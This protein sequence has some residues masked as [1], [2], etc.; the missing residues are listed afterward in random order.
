MSA[1]RTES[2]GESVFTAPVIV[3]LALM[4]LL[5]LSVGAAFAPLGPFKTSASLGVAGIKVVLIALVFMRL[6]RSSNLVR[7]AAGAGLMWAAFLFLL[8]G[9]DYISRG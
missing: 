1:K 3:W 7:L 9:A 4:T 5:F 6:N 8:A 2:G